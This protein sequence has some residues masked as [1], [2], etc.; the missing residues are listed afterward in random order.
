MNKNYFS[1]KWRKKYF[2]CI[3]LILCFGLAAFSGCCKTGS[4]NE[5]VEINASPTPEPFLSL[6]VSRD[7][8]GVYCG[9]NFT[10]GRASSGDIMFTGNCSSIYRELSNLQNAQAIYCGRGVAAGINSDGSVALTGADKERYAD[11]LN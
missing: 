8:T 10:I 7:I 5:I 6:S 4:D 2:L 3:L 11:A 1:K 9:D